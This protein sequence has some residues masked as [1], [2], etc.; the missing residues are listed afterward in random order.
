MSGVK[1]DNPYNSTH[2]TTCCEVAI[3][4]YQQKCPSCREDVYPFHKN[5]SDDERRQAH[6]G[7]MHHN[8]TRARDSQ[9]RA[10]AW[11]RK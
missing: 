8:T 11:W 10:S 4:D 9:A 3:L 2:F 6:G 7:Y 5:M 1:Y